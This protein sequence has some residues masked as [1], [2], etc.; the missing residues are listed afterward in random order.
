MSFDDS[1]AANVTVPDAAMK[2]LPAVAV[3]AT[4]WYFTVVVCCGRDESLT[5]KFIAFVPEFP[6][7]SRTSEI[8]ACGV[9]DTGPRIA[10]PRSTAAGDPLRHRRESSRSKNCDRAFSTRRSVDLER[11]FRIM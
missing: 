3:P 5:M 9:P 1:P 11:C 6:S 4:V 10:A 7:A 2:S 8:E